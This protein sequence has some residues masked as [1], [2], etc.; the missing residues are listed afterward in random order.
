MAVLILPSQG[1]E[2]AFFNAVSLQTQSIL[3]ITVRTLMRIRPCFLR[4]R[5]RLPACATLFSGLR[6]PRVEIYA[7]HVSG[8]KKM[9]RRI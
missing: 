7:G 6:V 8:I 5:S 9:Q 2:R 1:F 3:N 4:P